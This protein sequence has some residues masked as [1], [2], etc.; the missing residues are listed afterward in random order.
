LI[1]TGVIRL[2]FGMAR[3]LRKKN[4]A[5]VALTPGFLRS[6]VMLEKFGVTEANWRDAVKKVPDYAE[7]ETPLYAGRA[8]ACLAADP[9]VM[10]KSGRVFSS[11]GLSE[12]YPFC[13][14]DGRRPHFGRHFEKVYGHNMN[15]CDEGFYKYCFGGAIDTIFADWPKD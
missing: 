12:E 10:R 3:E 14:A 7:S 11:W 4:I 9:H 5:A 15:S 13:D 2:A 1:K 8:I 6:E